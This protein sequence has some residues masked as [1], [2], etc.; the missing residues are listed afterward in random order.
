MASFTVLLFHQEKVLLDLSSSVADIR[1]SNSASLEFL[2][3]QQRQVQ[4]LWNK[5]KMQ[6]EEEGISSSTAKAINVL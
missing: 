6:C 3:P 4:F 5:M 1:A 2:L